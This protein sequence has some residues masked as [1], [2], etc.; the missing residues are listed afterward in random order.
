M[1][2]DLNNEM[3]LIEKYLDGALTV[4]EQ[5]QVEQLLKERADLREV[6]QNMKM[7]IDSVR[8]AELNQ[9]VAAIAK[10][11]TAKQSTQQQPAKVRSIGFYTLRAAAVVLI[12][13]TSYTAA[14][15]ITATP[16]RLYN[17]EF[18]PYELP[19]TR[20]NNQ[21]TAIEHAYKN[22]DWQK[23]L[24]LAT[25]EKSSAQET[26]FLA[27]MASLQLDQPQQAVDYFERVLKVNT[28]TGNALYAN[29]SQFYQALAYVK[30]N[31]T[32]KA[33]ALLLKIRN[34]PDHPFYKE[35]K[36]INMLKIKLMN[37][38]K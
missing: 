13:V 7:A 22:A 33:Y 28:A 15:Y 3:D 36:G 19:A 12:S 2:Y 32:A 34:N 8:Y 35:A 18:V 4:K 27:G 14:M 16:E 38:K 11:Y 17:D 23:V 24:T 6:H 37:W 29:E 31:E 9:Q 5:A 21:S 10:E 25:T 26:L 20:N 30:Q 1:T